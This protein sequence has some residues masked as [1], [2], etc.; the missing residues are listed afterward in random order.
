MPPIP[1]RGPP[2]NLAEATAQSAEANRETA[3]HQEQERPKT[4]LRTMIRNQRSHRT[5]YRMISEAERMIEMK[6]TTN[7][8]RS[9]VL[10]ATLS[11]P[12]VAHAAG[13]SVEAA[14]RSDLNAAKGPYQDGVKAMNA[15]R[16]EEAVDKFRDSYNIVA[17][18]NSQLMLGRALIKLNRLMDAYRVL[19]EAVEKAT[20]LAAT[21]QKYQKTAE[22]A[23][24]E[25]ENVKLELAFVTVIPGTE[26]SLG[27][28]RLSAADWGKPQPMMP[29][30]TKI[31]IVAS[32]GRTREKNLR[33]DPGETKVLTADFSSTSS[34]VKRSGEGDQVEV[35]ESREE[36]SGGSSAPLTSRRNLGFISGGVGIVGAI[37]FAGLALYA[38]STFGNPEDCPSSQGCKK[39][40][41]RNGENKGTLMGLSYAML[42]IGVVGLGLGTYLV[43]TDRP[44]EPSSPKTAFG[45]GPGSVSIART[46]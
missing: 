15:G 31:E 10:V 25:M 3:L 5:T 16:F 34:R 40:D 13:V 35:E 41:V 36:S 19:Q 37:G 44:T 45:I 42:G 18:P 11:V 43:L 38:N 8:V 23:K 17:S 32:D 2:R 1:E 21:Q 46:F 28:R 26:V 14:S 9:L 20:D 30:R 12:I 7:L 27:G 4:N 24:R 33:L 29:G 6:C 22:S 39:A